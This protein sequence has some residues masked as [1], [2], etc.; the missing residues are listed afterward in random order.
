MRWISCASLGLWF[1]LATPAAGQI[2]G[3]GDVVVALPGPDATLDLDACIDLALQSNPGLREEREGLARLQAQKTQARA[4][5]FPTLELQGAWSRGRDPS[6]ALDESF[7]GSGDDDFSTLLPDSLD[8]S[9]IPDPADIPAQTFWRT[10]LDA[11]W[12]LRPTRVWRAVAAADGAVDQQEAAILDAEHRTIEAVVGA[13]HTV[14]L[15]RERMNATEREIAAREEF[16]AVTR[17]RYRLDF[18]TPLDTL[19]AAV[20]LEN[21]RPEQ[22]RRAK[23]LRRAGQQLNLLLGRAPLTPIAVVA[24]FP[25]EGQTL[26]AERALE[27]ALRRPDLEVQRR[28]TE[29]YELQRGVA[30]ANL[31]PYLTVE[32]QWGYVTRELSDLTDDGQDFWRAGIT[33]HVPIFDGFRVKGEKREAEAEIRRNQIAV[34]A[35]EASIQDEVLDAVENL[36]IARADL[37]AAQLNLTRAD[38]AYIQISLRYELGKADNLD[39]LNAQAERF[40]ARSTVIEARY[41]V[42]VSLATLKRA[43]GVSPTVPL[44]SLTAGASESFEEE[45][46]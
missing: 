8:F 12:E 32:G 31:H 36:E 22:R 39:V 5:G 44:A 17:R 46:R 9:F 14:V 18:A 24:T 29:L 26:A 19:Q 33:L 10:Y 16:L 34:D 7:G 43:I 15:A 28:T 23:D 11:Y 6:F 2:V 21:L 38:D 20:S 4:E 35:L 1:V 25:L 42:L 45:S 3:E 27:L 41:D 13:Y 30:A 37:R 40:T